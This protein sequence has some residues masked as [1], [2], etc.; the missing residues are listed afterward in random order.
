VQLQTTVRDAKGNIL[1][2]DRR[3]FVVPDFSVADLAIGAPVL[4]RA[5]TVAEARAIA[6]GRQAVP[7]AGREFIR[8]DRLFVRFTVYGAVASEAD[9]SAWLTN[10]A[11]ATL[12]SLRVAKMLARADAGNEYEIDFPL[13]SI[14]RGDYVIAVA[15][16]H[17]DE[18]ARSLVALRVVP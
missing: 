9:V 18:R 15:A 7:F 3:P 4:L 6:G 16:A 10:R 2:E 1:D 17:G 11:G 8:T 5:R 12:L 14:A 13:A